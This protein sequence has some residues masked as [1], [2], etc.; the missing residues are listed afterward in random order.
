MNTPPSTA[1]TTGS[2]SLA[3]A[4][5]E[6]NNATSYLSNNNNNTTTTIAN[7]PTTSS[8]P[9]FPQSTTPLDNNKPNNT[10]NI[11]ALPSTNN[12]KKV[13]IASPTTTAKQTTAAQSQVGFVNHSES[14]RSGSSFS[15]SKITLRTCCGVVELT[16]MKL[17]CLLGMMVTVIGL[18]VLA[19][20][21]VAAFVA[22]TTKSTDILIA[23]GKV[24]SI[25]ESSNALVLKYT[26]TGYS[27]EDQRLLVQ[28]EYKNSTQTLKKTLQ[29]ILKN[30]DDASIQTMFNSTTVEASNNWDGANSQILLIIR[31]QPEDAKTRLSSTSYNTIKTTFQE[32]LDKLVT[33]VQEKESTKDKNVLAI[34]LVQLIVIAVSLF[35]ILPIIVFVFTYAINRDSLYLEKI[36]RANAVMLMDTMEDDGLRTLFKIHCE[37]EKSTEN[38]LLLEK[39]HYYRSLCERS[40]DLQ[41][42]LFGE[43]NVQSDV[44]SEISGVS[45]DSAHSGKKKLSPLEKEYAEVEAKKYEVAFEIFTEFLEVT[46][47]MAV[48]IS[49]VLT[50]AVKDKLDSYN[51]KQIETLPE[52]MFNILEKETCLVMMDTHHRFKQS[53]AFQREMKIDKIKVDKLKKKKYDF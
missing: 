23:V 20:V 42:R 24:T 47:D 2:P 8:S 34:T 30:V 33:F 11:T 22:T 52:D 36:R 25:F 12:S 3:P 49:H 41:M 40:I 48:N 53:L 10:M 1:S 13:T 29:T 44:S 26:Y 28:E 7:N 27:S 18:L 21:A 46:G 9:S 17:A 38:F 32:G 6:A 4:S 37:K 19:G 39:I 45:G 35:V 43:S 31:T 50:D 16:S 51:D 14:G 15:Q 5:N